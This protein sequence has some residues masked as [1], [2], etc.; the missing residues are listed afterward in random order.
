MQENRP[1]EAETPP[2]VKKVEMQ[3]VEVKIEGENEENNKESETVGKWPRC[4]PFN[5]VRLLYSLVSFLFFSAALKEWMS[6]PVRVRAKQSPAKQNRNR[7]IRRAVMPY[8]R[9]AVSR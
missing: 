5:S 9:N 4:A 3:K 7:T 6:P 8:M 1:A 2:K